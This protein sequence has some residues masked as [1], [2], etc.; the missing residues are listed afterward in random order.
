MHMQADARPV[1]HEQSPVSPKR[2]C[3]TDPIS[4]QFQLQITSQ[5]SPPTIPFD[6]VTYFKGERCYVTNKHVEY[7]TSTSWF[8]KKKTVFKK[9]TQKGRLGTKYL[10][11]LQYSS[12]GVS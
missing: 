3:Y 10:C 11:H 7:R 6:P 4:S 8:L 1:P 2:V 5:P 12:S 9:R